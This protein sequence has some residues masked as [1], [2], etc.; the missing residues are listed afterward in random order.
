MENGSLKTVEDLLAINGFNSESIKQLHVLCDPASIPEYVVPDES[1]MPAELIEAYTTQAID[2]GDMPDL[3]EDSPA[4]DKSKNWY[5]EQIKKGGAKL[6]LAVEPKQIK[7]DPKSIRTFTTINQSL[8][9]INWTEFS[10]YDESGWTKGVCV[11]K[12]YIQDA[13]PVLTDDH[14]CQKIKKLAPII[15]RIPV[16]DAYVLETNPKL[17]LNALRN[18]LSSKATLEIVQFSQLSTILTTILTNRA[19]TKFGTIDALNV[20]FIGSTM[21]GKLFGLRLRKETVSTQPMIRDIL[22]LQKS[23]M[24]KDGFMID[25]SEEWRDIFFKAYATNKEGLG[26]CLLIGLTFVHLGLQAK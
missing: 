15:N 19:S 23:Q 8:T 1:Q 11:N 9:G 26:K 16:S 3:N 5:T 7:I 12:G 14:L 22:K 18:T 13:L 2:Y 10:R 6:K 20:H 24:E 25:I 4:T 17:N 21:V